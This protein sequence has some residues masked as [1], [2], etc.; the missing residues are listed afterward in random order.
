MGGGFHCVFC[1]PFNA[2]DCAMKSAGDAKEIKFPK[3]SLD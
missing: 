1:F 3:L 2:D